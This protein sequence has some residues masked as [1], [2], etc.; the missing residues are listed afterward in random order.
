MMRYLVEAQG[1]E[2][3]HGSL[4]GSLC[5]WCFIHPICAIHVDVPRVAPSCSTLREIPDCACD[6]AGDTALSIAYHSKPLRVSLSARPVSPE[7][8][9]NVQRATLVSKAER[10]Y[11]TSK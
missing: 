9:H 8:R 5:V 1:F 6:L 11:Y 2:I 10:T 7:T 4:Y 3:C